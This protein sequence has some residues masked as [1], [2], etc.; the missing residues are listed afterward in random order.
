MRASPQTRVCAETFGQVDSGEETMQS[1][2]KEEHSEALRQHLAG[3]MS[4]SE[5]ADAINAK[6]RTN[7]T[8]SAAIGRAKRT[9]LPAPRRRDDWPKSLA[10][11]KAPRSLKPFERYASETWRIMPAFET[12]TVNLRCVE[13]VPR[14]LSLIDL[15]IGDCRYAYG[16]DEEG[17]A[18]TFCGHPQRPGTSYCTPHFHLTRGP[19]T[20]SERAAGN[21]SLR[22]VAA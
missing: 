10:S 16:G 18:I 1:T 11:G 19:G 5:A 12:E 14:H 9:G 7:Y 4:F 20:P 17:Q 22:L 21:V 8:R 6:F 3:G 15:E 2:W 13:I